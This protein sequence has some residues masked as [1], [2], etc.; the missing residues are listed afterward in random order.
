MVDIIATRIRSDVQLYVPE[1]SFSVPVRHF[2]PANF[3]KY[4][5]QPYLSTIV[6]HRLDTVMVLY[7]RR[8]IRRTITTYTLLRAV[9]LSF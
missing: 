8:I 4:P 3:R 7:R 9:M 2:G 1:Y 6:L 5:C